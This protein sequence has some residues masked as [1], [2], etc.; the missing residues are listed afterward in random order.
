MILWSTDP[1]DWAA[2][3]S[4]KS[5]SVIRT[6]VAAGLTEE[7]PVILLH[8]GGGNRSTTVGALQGIIDDY[9]AGGYQFVTLAE[10]G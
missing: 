6:R 2:S 3:A 5:A 4:K 1:R 8:D 7:H 10:P 9:R